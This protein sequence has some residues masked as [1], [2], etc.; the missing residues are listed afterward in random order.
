MPFYGLA[1]VLLIAKL[2]D[3]VDQI[4]GMQMM[5]QPQGRSPAFT[6]GGTH[7]PSFRH[8]ANASKTWLVVKPT[9]RDEATKLFRNTKSRS[10]VRAD[11]ILDQPLELPAIT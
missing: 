4:N 10:L 9:F 11:P 3:S 2:S 5:Q 1:T 7:G 8:F 6:H